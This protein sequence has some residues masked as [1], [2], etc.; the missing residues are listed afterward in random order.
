MEKSEL[1]AIL[2]PIL[3]NPYIKDKYAYA[4]AEIDK[5][6][7]KTQYNTREVGL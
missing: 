6:Y 5:T 1:I 2:K 3:S 7:Q 4:K